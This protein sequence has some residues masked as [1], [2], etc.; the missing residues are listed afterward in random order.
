M[1]LYVYSDAIT[2]ERVK[3]RLFIAI[4]I[5]SFDYFTAFYGISPIQLIHIRNINNNLHRESDVCSK[6]IYEYNDSCDIAVHSF[7]ILVSSS[8]VFVLRHFRVSFRFG[9]R[10]LHIHSGWAFSSAHS[11]ANAHAI[12]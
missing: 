4:Q 8:N 12:E 6:Y 9:R 1:E 11:M 7:I 5:I 3:S 2:A 10:I